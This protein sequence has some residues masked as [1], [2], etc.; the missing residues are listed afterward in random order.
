MV[1][2]NIPAL[3]RYFL[4]VAGICI[5]VPA[6]AQLTLVIVHSGAV[7][8]LAVERDR[9][10]TRGMSEST[11]S[12][13]VEEKSSHLSAT[14]G[15]FIAVLN[16]TGGAA[17]KVV[18]AG[19]NLLQQGIWNTTLFGSV[20]RP[21]SGS[22]V[23]YS[24]TRSPLAVQ[25]SGAAGSFLKSSA[26]INLFGDVIARTYRS[27][28]KLYIVGPPEN[29]FVRSYPGAEDT[30]LPRLGSSPESLA[31]Y[32]ERAREW[33]QW[34]LYPEMRER[35]QSPVT[36]DGPFVRAS[37]GVQ[38]LTMYYPLWDSANKR[39]AG[40]VGLDYN[41]SRLIEL[42]LSARVG[43]NG[44]AFVVDG[45]GRVIA[46]PDSGRRLYQLPAPLGEGRDG[47]KPKGVNLADS[48]LSMIRNL[49]RQL[50]QGDNGILHMSIPAPQSAELETDASL[51]SSDAADQ[52]HMLVYRIFR[53]MTLTGYAQD[54]WRL[55]VDVR[56]DD[57][58]RDSETLGLDIANLDLRA[59]FL[60]VLLGLV[61]V[62]VGGFLVNQRVRLLEPELH[63]EPFRRIDMPAPSVGPGIPAQETKRID[64]QLMPPSSATQDID[65][66]LDIALLDKDHDP[67]YGPSYRFHRIGS[68]LY[69]E[70]GSSAP[71][72]VL[73]SLKLIT[74]IAL[75][76]AISPN[77]GIE[78]VR[79]ILKDSGGQSVAMI[80]YQDKIFSMV[81][82]R[83][84]GAILR[85]DGGIEVLG[86]TEIDGD[87]EER[88][89]SVRQ[90]EAL[91]IVLTSQDGVASTTGELSG[92]LRR[93]A[94][95]RSKSSVAT[96]LFARELLG[97]LVSDSE[98]HFAD[99]SAIIV[100]CPAYNSQA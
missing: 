52:N 55:V 19:Q 76:K 73:D 25:E 36:I 78:S 86:Q 46:I 64:T 93:F 51:D 74:R 95:R 11:T 10:K 49:A 85:Q 79:Q 3:R 35:F 15:T 48:G 58:L 2:R 50:N 70:F 90:G 4:L 68:A 14:I 56:E 81:G 16:M 22:G 98:Q 6:L 12:L 40:V 44:F 65:G 88:G 53:P 84:G 20:S 24:L 29:P 9:A 47:I 82:H 99:D 26:L 27:V 87:L 45:S 28:A 41:L 66:D 97:A 61:G 54:Q 63:T 7:Q 31:E 67:A 43:K 60:S 17:Q 75:G 38:L 89:L 92:S 5:L 21:P 57:L 77:M 39:I 18:D 100:I 62:I 32:K 42:T 33:T 94:D 91:V 59:V 96:R 34:F 80:E 72:T 37:D 30:D 23:D 8:T 1:S 71:A 83:V 69:I 13:L